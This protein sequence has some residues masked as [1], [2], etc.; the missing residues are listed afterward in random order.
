M[1]GTAQSQT[2]VTYS[3]G[4][5]GDLIIGQ[6]FPL[7]IKITSTSLIDPAASIIISNISKNIH[8]KDYIPINSSVSIP[9]INSP[10]NK[11][12]SVTILF[13]VESTTNY[14]EDI[15][16]DISAKSVDGFIDR[17]YRRQAKDIDYDTL[18]LIV[19]NVYLTAPY[20][21][22]DPESDSKTAVHTVIHDKKNKNALSDVPIFI[23]SMQESKIKLFDYFD[24][25]D[26]NPIPIITLNYQTG[27]LLHSDSEGK[28]YFNIHAQ[29]LLSGRIQLVSTIPGIYQQGYSQPIYAIYGGPPVDFEHSTRFPS[30][31]G[32][33]P[34]GNLT[35]DGQKNFLVTISEYSEPKAG[36]VVFFL[37]AKGDGNA[38]YSGYSKM[39]EDIQNDIGTPSIHVPYQ[40]FEYG[41][42]SHFS[43]VIV[44]ISGD[45]LTSM[46][47]PLTYMGGTPYIPDER[48]NRDYQACIVYTS[49]GIS[50]H[51]IIPNHTI[52]NLDSIIQYPGGEGTGLFIQIL[53]TDDPTEGRVPVG[54]QVTLTSYIN[55]GNVNKIISYP[56]TEVKKQ[57]DDSL[58]AE[59]HIPYD[60]LYNIQPFN[61]VRVGNIKFTYEFTYKGKKSYSKIW[62]AEIETVPANAPDDDNN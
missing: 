42:L 14:G 10:D 61:Y 6:T 2:N 16:F 44:R 25:N 62:S 35:S 30:I 3:L 46:S 32:Y 50:Q 11:S 17:Q 48:V 54:T 4:E 33:Y 43:Y 23:S 45:S 22:T 21:N 41:V 18:N 39:I 15:T 20:S 29:K 27:L 37:V 38:K 1:D 58:Y 36:D 53:G 13:S 7:T 56:P 12:A 31:V 51:T 47:L 26:Q 24:A 59:I 28:V 40:I 49:L 60:D 57:K 34:P 8:I 5:N 52:V 9:L 55:S 19:D